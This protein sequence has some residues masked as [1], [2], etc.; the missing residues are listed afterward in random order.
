MSPRGGAHAN[1]RL[2]K[3]ARRR[4][5]SEGRTDRADVPAHDDRKASLSVSEGDGGRI[6]LKCHAGC[7]A[8]AI[9]GALG[10]TMADLF[11]EKRSNGNGRV[12]ETAYDYRD[13]DGKLLFQ[14]VRYV[15]KKFSQRRPDGAGGFI[16]DL[17]GVRRVPYR[18]PELL[19]A[20]CSATVFLP[21]GE[22][23][24]DNLRARGLVA[25]CNPMGA[26]KW[27]DEYSDFLTGREVV[28]LP[29]ND[30]PG[31]DHARAIARSLVG[32]ASSVK[33]LALSGLPEKGDVSNWLSLGG[34]VETLRALAD[35]APE[36]KPDAESSTV[37]DAGRIAISWGA[38]C[39]M[40][41]ER[42][43]RY[44]TKSS[45]ARS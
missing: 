2:P 21:E 15:G 35:A 19:A 43:K 45:A 27:R 11:V 42:R 32:A 9:A 13:E 8:D 3:Q 16:Y 26:G 5:I 23:D 4:E 39:E 18:L 1:W 14:A 12:I 29:D 37:T 30:D 20:D 10:L 17:E 24:V 40:K 41:L 44:S 28:I 22:Q 7:E 6:L 25:T 38:L 33:V 34:T 36:W 31:R